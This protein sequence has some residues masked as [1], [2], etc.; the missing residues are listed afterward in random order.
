MFPSSDTLGQLAAA[1]AKAQT[2]LVNPPKILRATLPPDARG[3]R[4][5]YR[6]A[7]LST[8]LT[9]V[10]KAL[11]RH[12]LAVVQTTQ[13]DPDNGQVDLTTPL[14]HGSGEWI[15]PRWPVCDG[16]ARRDPKLMGAALTYARRYSLF[17]LVGVA[18]EDDLDAPRLVA[19]SSATGR[20]PRRAGASPPSRVPVQ[21][22]RRSSG[23]R[24]AARVIPLRALRSPPAVQERPASASP[25]IASDQDPGDPLV[26]LAQ[27]SS[28]DALLAWAVAALPRRGLLDPATRA[29]WDEA[30][31]AKA[32]ALGI[33]LAALFASPVEASSPRSD[34]VTEG[35]HHAS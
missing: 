29:S 21:R 10:R 12:Q 20:L 11:G 35:E 27:V 25:E 19:S 9:I 1:L 3:E 23:H 14:V 2:E 16:E 15:A 34:A 4:P 28:E 26:T 8:G 30:F 17:A 7:S 6:Y 22:G 18:G 13:V 31:Q 24:P 32:D 33:S 5:S